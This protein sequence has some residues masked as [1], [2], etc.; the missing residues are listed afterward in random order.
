MTPE[1]FNQIIKRHEMFKEY[2][3]SFIF[4]LQNIS[5][6]EIEGLASET[7]KYYIHEKW[8]EV[9]ESAHRKIAIV[10]PFNLSMEWIIDTAISVGCTT[11][12]RG[13]ISTVLF[14]SCP[15][16]T[17]GSMLAKQKI[18]IKHNKDKTFTLL[19]YSGSFTTDFTLVIGLFIDLIDKMS[20]NHQM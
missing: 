19:Y 3:Q 7:S 13:T 6:K 5:N 9:L 1:E 8:S 12:E 18:G 4:C 15:C 20:Q 11:L 16:V 17:I 10:V 14:S 2:F